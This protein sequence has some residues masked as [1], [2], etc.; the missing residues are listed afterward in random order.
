MTKDRLAL[1]LSLFIALL[2]WIPQKLT[3]S[4]RH[5]LL[6]KISL[7]PPSNRQVS[8]KAVALVPLELTGSGNKL[9]G[10]KSAIKFD[11]IYIP[12]SGNG[13]NPEIDN[14]TLFSH[15]RQVYNIPDAVSLKTEINT[16]KF[17]LDSI[18]TKEVYILDDLNISYKSGFGPV[19]NIQ[20]TPDRLRISG[21]HEMLNRIDTLLTAPQTLTAVDK[22]MTVQLQ[23]EI[24]SSW[25]G[26]Q[27]GQKF[28]QAKIE[29]DEMA[30]KEI[31][32]SLNDYKNDDKVW[33]L[34]PDK[35]LVKVSLP[36]SKYSSLSSENIH[37]ELIDIGD[38]A[39]AVEVRN[40]PHDVRL[41]NYSPKIIRYFVQRSDTL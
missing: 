7:D 31:I 23:I 3:K 19:G 24:D 22:N 6:L 9:T 29:V 12:Y 27:V 18:T 36:L 34:F 32:I 25:R 40:L 21:P 5:D 28:V 30:E 26:V 37:L 41:I 10:I 38:Q 4:Y 16:V 1:G 15:I 11:T 2:L 20:L 14:A 33:K 8:G 35:V 17:L 13:L 39:A